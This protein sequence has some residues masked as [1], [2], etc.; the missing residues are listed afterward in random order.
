MVDLQFSFLLFSRV[1]AML[2]LTLA[3]E[4]GKLK[5][6]SCRISL[7]L[8]LSLWISSHQLYTFT[9][10]VGDKSKAEVIFRFLARRQGHQGMKFVC[11][12]VLES[13]HISQSLSWE[14]AGK[15]LSHFRFLN[16]SI[17]GMLLNAVTWRFY[18]LWSSLEDASLLFWGPYLEVQLSQWFHI[19]LISSIQ[20]LSVWST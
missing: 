17:G 18:F 2:S 14:A 15:W 16:C 13:S 3:A 5:S 10:N 19:P 8:I 12:H 4:S 6:T 7:K 1:N 11:S 20:F 9:G